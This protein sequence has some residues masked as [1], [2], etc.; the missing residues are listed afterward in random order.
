MNSTFSLDND[1]DLSA[2]NLGIGVCSEQQI[3]GMRYGKPSE[4]KELAIYFEP[5]VRINYY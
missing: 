3:H 5:N 2:Y 1:D 4:D